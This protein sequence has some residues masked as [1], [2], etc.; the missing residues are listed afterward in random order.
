[1]WCGGGDVGRARPDPKALQANLAGSDGYAM[2]GAAATHRSHGPTARARSLG[3]RVAGPIDRDDLARLNSLLRANLQFA[4]EPVCSRD[5]GCVGPD[6]P[7][8]SSPV[9]APAATIRGVLTHR[10]AGGRQ[11]SAWFPVVCSTARRQQLHSLARSLAECAMILGL[12]AG[13]YRGSRDVRV[14]D[15]K[16]S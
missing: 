12:G 10:A 11:R 15:G 16:S 5:P 2:R 8:D 7:R 9:R 6:A 13:V 1:M 3:R 14:P 4:V